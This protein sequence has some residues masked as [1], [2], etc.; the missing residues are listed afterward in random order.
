[1]TVFLL[2]VEPAAMMPSEEM[3]DEVYLSWSPDELACPSQMIA[4]GVVDME[5]ELEDKSSFNLTNIVPSQPLEP[6]PLR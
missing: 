2:S 4:K 3:A 1:M 6:D 5:N